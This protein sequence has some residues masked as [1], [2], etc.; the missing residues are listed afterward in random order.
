MRL[1]RTPMDGMARRVGELGRMIGPKSNVLAGVDLAALDV[2]DG[3]VP[4]DDAAEPPVDGAD[5]VAAG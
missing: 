2:G 1:V 4:G 5:W 3:V